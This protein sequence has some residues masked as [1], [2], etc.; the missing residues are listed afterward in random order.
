LGKG[1]RAEEGLNRRAVANTIAVG[2][3]VLGII[4]G[5][6][7]YYLVSTYQTKTV[8]F[9][10]TTT[11]TNTATLTQET[12]FSFTQ[13]VSTTVSTTVTATSVTT[14]I[15]TSSVYPL[16]TN[17]TVAFVNV[18]GY[19]Q[20]TIQ[21]GSSFNSSEGTGPYSLRINGVFPGESF[22]ITARTGDISGCHT[23]QMLTMRLWVNGFMVSQSDT[24]C[25]TNPA[26]ITYTV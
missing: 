3:L 6:T 2:L 18:V 22:T 15:S 21:V 17:V 16:P 9:T 25:G 11:Q 4:I 13:T 8:S 1:R 5:V 20:Y 24:S 19:Y 26:S 23:G 14:S 12:S 10:Q 7:G